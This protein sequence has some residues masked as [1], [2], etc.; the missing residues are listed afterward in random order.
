MKYL[1][2][3]T[4]LLTFPSLWGGCNLTESGAA[5]KSDQKHL[6]QAVLWQQNAAEYRALAYQTYTLARIQF[7]RT[8][9]ERKRSASS[10][11]V[12]TDI[13][14]TV[15]DNSRF[16]GKMIELNQSFSNDLWL[17]WGEQVMADTVPGALAFFKHVAD[18]GVEVY[19]ISNRSVAQLTATIKNLKKFSFPFADESHV[20]LKDTTSD[21]EARRRMVKQNHQIIMLLGD[22]LT[23]FS[24]LFYRQNSTRRNALVDSLK[25]IFGKRFIVFPNPM[26]GDWETQGIFEGRYDWSVAQTDSIRY[27]KIKA[28]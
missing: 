22:N 28:Y 24:S 17:E 10:L 2:Y 13:D 26:Y 27:H 8:L 1:F 20:L 3:L 16:E 11:A 9:A 19:Y 6:I 5:S 21:K 25:T 7:D 4:L 14:E 18:N 23:D 12:V 15:L